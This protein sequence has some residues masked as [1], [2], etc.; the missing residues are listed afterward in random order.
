VANPHAAPEKQ[1]N[2]ARVHGPRI[3][4]QL[5]DDKFEDITKELNAQVTSFSTTFLGGLASIEDARLKAH[6]VRAIE[7]LEPCE[8]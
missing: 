8:A 6:L 3:F 2:P 1:G 4:Y 5:R 7:R